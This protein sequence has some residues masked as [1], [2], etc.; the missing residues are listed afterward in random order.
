MKK[1]LIMLVVLL[2]THS[3]CAESAF[4]PVDTE[5]FLPVTDA[6][7]VT[8]LEWNGPILPA[9]TA[10]ELLE[11]AI[12]GWECRLTETNEAVHKF[13][14]IAFSDENGESHEAWV[15]AHNLNR[16][17]PAELTTEEQALSYARRFLGNQYVLADDGNGDVRITRQENGWLAELLNQSSGTTHELL[18]DPKGRVQYYLDRS[19]QAPPLSEGAVHDDALARLADT[20]GMHGVL[21]WSSRELLPDVGYNS[22]AT[23]AY[24][25]AS[26][27]FTFIIDGFD[28]YVALQAEPAVRMVAYGDLNTAGGRYAGCLSRDQARAIAAEALVSECGLSTGSTSL[29]SLLQADLCIKPDWWTSADVPLPYWC[30]Q[31][32]LLPSAAGE[33]FQEYQVLIDA[34]TGDVLE[35]THPGQMANG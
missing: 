13:A 29:L 16:A 24:D 11:T 12:T 19:Y 17:V 14:R 15:M 34:S 2:F 4:L 21:E 28:Y 6:D 18:V 10:F 7:G 31:F 32:Q 1:L 23:V 8:R 35:I 25:E 33:A 5:T 3:A 27:I 20:Y 9:G 22:V 26:K 30:L